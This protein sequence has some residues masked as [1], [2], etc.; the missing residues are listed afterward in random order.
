MLL[1]ISNCQQNTIYKLL[2]HNLS[3]LM[4]PMMNLLQIY[5]QLLKNGMVLCRNIQKN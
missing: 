1:H 2:L 5:Y 4:K 3:F